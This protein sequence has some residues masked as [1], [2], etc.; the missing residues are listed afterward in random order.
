MQAPLPSSLNTN[1]TEILGIPVDPVTLDEAVARVHQAAVQ[2]ERL[3]I[4]TPNLNF[5]A[6]CHRDIEF[7]NALKRSDLILVDGTPLVWLGRLMGAPIPE[8]VAGSDLFEALRLHPNPAESANP[9]KVFFF[10]GPDGVAKKAHETLNAS[11][12]NM[13]SVG[14]HYP[15][16]GSITDMSAPELLAQINATGAHFLVVSLGA[17]KGQAWIVQNMEQL[18]IPVISHLGAVVNFVAGEVNRAPMWMRKVGL[19]WLW[20][21]KEE[22]SLWRRYAAD[23]WLVSRILFKRI[24][25]KKDGGQ[26]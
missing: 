7:L 3:F 2:H 10:G 6:Q 17:Q 5:L 9:L 12:S 25:K 1:R 19:E 20:R 13:R 14:Y 18:T 21:I 22:P 4:S 11:H 16:H 26:K 23:A 8:R 15:G 24:V